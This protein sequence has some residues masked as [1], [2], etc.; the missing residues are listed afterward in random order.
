MTE[1]AGK[2]DGVGVEPVATRVAQ[3]LTKIALAMRSH[4]WHMGS[5]AGLTPTQAQ[6]LVT[7][8]RRKGAGATVTEVADELAVAPATVSQALAALERKGLVLRAPAAEDRRVHLVSLTDDGRQ[9]AEQVA[10]WPDFLAQAVG[11]LSEQEQVA[12]LRAL[13]RLIRRLQLEGY[14]KVARMCVSCRFFRPNVHD[15]PEA[16]HHCAYVDAPFGD[17]SLRV[18]CPD[19]WPRQASGD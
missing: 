12:F 4:A 5:V 19:Y 11:E 1:G 8:A 16:P 13:V 7:L 18:D 17:R 3:G 14:I 9:A 10:Q 6:A 15:D 2:A